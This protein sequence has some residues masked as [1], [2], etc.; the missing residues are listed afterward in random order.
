MLITVI[1]LL[2]MDL[3]DCFNLSIK[4]DINIY[5]GLK[6]MNKS[7]HT[8]PCHTHAHTNSKK[9]TLFFGTSRLTYLLVLVI[10]FEVNIVW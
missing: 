6:R 8:P 10:Q 2:E 4:S 7:I 5:I 3:L 1:V 9:D